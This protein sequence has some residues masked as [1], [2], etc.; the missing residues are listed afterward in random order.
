M[1]VSLR[2]GRLDIVRLVERAQA[3][4]DFEDAIAAAAAALPADPAAILEFFDVPTG[5]A[6]DVPPA[7][8]IGYF[9]AKKLKPTFSYADM[10]DTAHDHAFTVAKMMDV[11][12]LGQIRASMDSALANGVSFKQWTDEITPILQSGGWWGRKAV[13]DPLTGQ[14][15]VA[16]LGSPWRL[17]TIF[18]TNMQSSYAAGAWQEIEAQ[19]DV[20][21]FLMYDAID[22]FRTRDLHRAWDRTV[23]PVT[24]NWWATH[25]PPNGYNCRCGVIQMSAEELDALGIAPN[26]APPKSGTYDW[27][28]PRTGEEL[29]IPNGIDPGFVHNAGQSYKWKLKQL[30]KEKIDALPDD[31]AKAAA[32]AKADAVKMT[33]EAVAAAQ[34]AQT[35]VA[36]AASAA[37]LQRAK[38]LAEQKAAEWAAAQQ[39]EAI[40][41]GNADAIGKGAAYKVKALQQLKK[42]DDWATKKPTE[43]L[44]AIDALAGDFKLK[45]ETA[46]K[47]SVYKKA[48][49]EGKTPPPNT[50]KAFQSLPEADQQA[51]LAKIDAEKAAIE[52]KKAAD[53]AEAAKKAAGAEPSDALQIAEPTPPNPDTMVVIGR[54]TKGGTQGAF[55]QDT[56]TGQ[57]YLVKFNGSED[58]VL[59]EVLAG[60]L[61]NLAGVEAP[62]LHSIVINGQP[63]LA[64]RI[65]DGIAEVDAATLARTASAQEG[66]AVDAWLAN[67]DSVG[68]NYDNTVL[69]GGRALRIDVGGSLRYRALGGLKG[70][71]FG[72]T[73]GEIDSLRDGTNPQARAVFGNITQQQIER[74]VEKVLRVRDADIKALVDKHGP[75]DA[76]E[77]AALADLLIARKADL[78]RR[79]PAAAQRVQADAS[80]ASA[81]PPP[82]PR[83]TAGEQQFI[84]DARVNGYGMATDGDQIEDH[85]VVVSTLKRADGSDATRGWFKMR[86]DASRDLLQRIASTAQT[87][88]PGVSLTDARDRILAAVKSINYRAD[89]GQPYDNTVIGKTMDAIRAIDDALAQIKAKRATGT[90]VNPA[91]LDAAESTLTE[92]RKELADLQ[93][94]MAQA[95]KASKL[96]KTFPYASIPDAVDFV[97]AAGQQAPAGLAWRKVTGQYQFNTATFDRSFAKETNGTSSVYGV[98]LRYEATLP[99]GTTITYFPHNSQVVYAMQGV[100]KIDAPGASRIGTSRVFDAIGEMGVDNRRA[101]ELDRKH[102]YL[103]AFARLRLVTAKASASQRQYYA[104]LGNDEAALQEKLFFLKK[105]TGVDVEASDAWSNLDGVRQAFGHGRAYQLR[106]DLTADQVRELNRTHVVFHNPQGLGTDAGSGVFDRLK[107]VIEGGGMMASLTDRVR[108]GVP[109]AGSSVSSDLGTGGGD[110]LFTRIRERSSQTG[111]GVYWRTNT[112]RRMDAIT[113][114]SDQFGNTKGAHIENNRLG[115]DIDSFKKVAPFSGNE[116]IFK[117]GLSIF[118]DLDRIVLAS[119]AEVRD[120]ITWMKS[121]GYK[122]WPDGRALDDVIISKAKHARR[123]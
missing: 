99:D 18:R 119:D 71:A 65:V 61:Y 85:M 34:Q 17:Q 82:P 51:L 56:A 43:Q 115:Q 91:A 29:V 74:G 93:P 36:K 32:K 10:L 88:D 58:A 53:A 42:A 111:A 81:P 77:R 24:D 45:T 108:R 114:D 20:A 52:A 23:L 54:K 87:A 2:L 78:A 30:L 95:G 96:A 47:L 118:D 38:M 112:L 86:P 89:K 97:P 100:V 63:A 19:K 103:N 28:N 69:V 120:A 5:D 75:R 80:A 109:L 31:M 106:P 57:K 83:V 12:M 116:T 70:Q 37:A 8:A 35:E 73:V 76:A 72:R 117:A 121:K 104:N 123:P 92:W 49:L 9:K 68:L 48:I 21:P 7:Q 46:S 40:A 79:Y 107:S 44:A 84:E 25:Y 16:Q 41:K 4:D 102:L 14:E 55:Y 110:Y 101:T 122:T 15:I 22:D 6:F 1:S 113:Y 90:A 50:V 39:V 59:N 105:A 62:E 94:I 60:R 13:L 98:E 27:T 67:W 11:D 26:T 33:Q 3:M 64:S 66:F